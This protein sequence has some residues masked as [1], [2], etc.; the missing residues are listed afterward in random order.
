MR[1]KTQN[2]ITFIKKSDTTPANDID[3]PVDP[4]TLNATVEDIN[5]AV[6]SIGSA[7]ARAPTLRPRSGRRKSAEPS[8]LTLLAAEV[9]LRLSSP[10]VLSKFFIE[11]EPLILGLSHRAMRRYSSKQCAY[12][13]EDLTQEA[14][15]RI[16]KA[17]NTYD[18]QQC[19]FEVFAAILTYRAWLTL[20][21]GSHREPLFSDDV[22]AS[23]EAQPS[24]DSSI[25]DVVDARHCLAKFRSTLPAPSFLY[26]V[27]NAAGSS[28]EEIAATYAQKRETV[29]SRLY[30]DRQQCVEAVA[31]H[32]LLAYL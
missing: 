8:P 29:K 28:S 23:F 17:L 5:D 19:P 1:S 21:Y 7:V 18:S 25:E 22:S 32:P 27:S 11:I 14:R 12:D 26:L 4:S 10:E 31:D 20:I 30:R 9:K 2:P 16:L 24:K 15:C 6:A 3:D 13:V